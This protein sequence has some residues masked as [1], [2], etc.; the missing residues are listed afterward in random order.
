MKNIRS[1]IK[2][3]GIAVLLCCMVLVISCTDKFDEI[4][5]DKNAIATL[6]DSQ[7]PFLFSAALQTGT[8]SGWSYQVA[9]NLFHDQYAQYFANTT[10]Y[11]PSDRLV[12]RMDWIGSLWEPQYVSTMPQLQTLME[13]YD[14]ASAEY[15]LANIWWVLSFQRITDTWGPIPYFNAGKLDPTI[16]YDPQDQIYD[17]FFKRLKSSVDILK[18]KTTESPYSSFD[19]I[20]GGNISKWIK[21]ANTL[22]LRLAVRISNV[23]PGRAKSEAEAAVADGVM[24]ASPVDDA[25]IQKS[26][27]N[28]DVNGLSVMDWNEFRMSSAMESVLKGYEDPRMPVYFN[29]TQNSILANIKANSGKF[30]PDDLAHPLDFNGLRNGLTAADMAVPLNHYNENSRHG[31]RWNSA[32]STVTYLGHYY[33]VADK[34][35]AKDSTTQYTAGQAV[36]SNVMGAAEAYFLRAE[37]VLLNWNM[38]AGTA[39][40]FY[41]A[42]ITASM[43]QWGITDPAE[44]TAYINSTATPIPPQDAQNSPALS[45]VPVLFG[46]TT[47]VQLEQIAVQKWLALFPDGNEAWADVRRSGYLKLYPVVK[48]DNADITDPATQT[49]RR[50]PFMLSEKASNARAVDDA[51]PLLGSGGDKVTTP[52][53]WDTN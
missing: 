52:L 40:S 3:H 1:F 16:P 29:P 11:F 26:I 17:D 37:G 47:A 53:W 42:G 33:H 18:T 49:I 51:V 8:N 5:T 28:S 4:N 38:G 23:D 13:K 19:L 35:Y 44:I 20:Y 21:F 31:Q 50:I 41:E 45:T 7:L 32:T 14:P 15:A 25:L 30:N 39:K 2:A 24:T 10:T 9:Q 46:A 12:I 43:N 6:E 27:V 48:S 34:W 22:R 36:P